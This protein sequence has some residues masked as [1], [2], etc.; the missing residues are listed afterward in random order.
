MQGLSPV[1]LHLSADFHGK[2]NALAESHG[3]A[4]GD[5]HNVLLEEEA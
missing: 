5:L 3:L 1:S 2:S 4:C